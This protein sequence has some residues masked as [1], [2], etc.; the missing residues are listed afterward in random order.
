M[1]KLDATDHPLYDPLKW[2]IGLP[3]IGQPAHME[4]FTSAVYSGCGI[5]ET[6]AAVPLAALSLTV[7]HPHGLEESSGVFVVSRF[8]PQRLYPEHPRSQ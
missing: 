3:L 7:Q 5:L 8:D 1:K 6:V 4:Q 2:L